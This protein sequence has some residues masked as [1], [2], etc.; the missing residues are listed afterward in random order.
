MTHLKSSAVA[1]AATNKNTAA[2]ARL[3]VANKNTKPQI[4][5]P[6]LDHSKNG[7]AQGEMVGYLLVHPTNKKLRS[8]VE[9]KKVLEYL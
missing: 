8:T 9:V 4:A 2:A 5:L 7:T 1:T 6:P 3:V